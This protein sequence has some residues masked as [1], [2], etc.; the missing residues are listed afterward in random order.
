MIQV[1]LIL[2]VDQ[3][4]VTLFESHSDILPQRSDRLG[5]LVLANPSIV[6]CFHV[7]KKQ[8]GMSIPVDIE[9]FNTSMRLEKSHDFDL[10]FLHKVT[11]V[12]V[13]PQITNELTA[14]EL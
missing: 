3:H 11:M 12:P 10:R 7:G 5:K 8:E 1:P 6:F 14:W 9:V 13:D 2:E 4:R